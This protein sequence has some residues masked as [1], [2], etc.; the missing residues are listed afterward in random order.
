M[1]RPCVEP[2][3]STVR[4][5]R[6]MLSRLPCQR[7]G[8][9]FH[10]NCLSRN[11]LPCRLAGPVTFAVNVTVAPAATFAALVETVVVV[12]NGPTGGP[13][14]PVPPPP[15]PPPPPADLPPPSQPTRILVVALNPNA[16]YPRA[17]HPVSQLSIHPRSTPSFCARLSIRLV[18]TATRCHP[19][20]RVFCIAK[21]SCTVPSERGN[22][23]SK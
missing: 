22:P 19:E 11:P 9:L 13:P 7:Q 16:T 1:D 17:P 2:S 14:P 5:K 12:A 23:P 18:N 20:R 10:K 4:A 8:C 21:D 3:E 15:P 6:V